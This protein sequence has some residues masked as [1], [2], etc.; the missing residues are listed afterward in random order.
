[1]TGAGKRDRLISLQ[2]FTAT[3]DDYGEPVE[4]WAEIGRAWAAVY[5]GKGDERRQAARE[6]GGQAASFVILSTATA[7]SLTIRDRISLGADL[8]DI[9]GISPIGRREIEFTAT[10]GL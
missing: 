9:V 8:W 1:M 7:R 6:A 3:A 10:R 2:R 5:F 4:T